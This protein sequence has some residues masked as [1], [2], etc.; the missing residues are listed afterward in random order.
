MFQTPIDE[1]V[2]QI[3]SAVY[4]G[5]G[6][7]DIAIA[8]EANQSYIDYLEFLGDNLPKIGLSV[9][10]EIDGTRIRFKNDEDFANWLSEKMG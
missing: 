6:D 10:V 7:R 5:A 1:Q 9:T 3:T 2:R 8:I 4:D